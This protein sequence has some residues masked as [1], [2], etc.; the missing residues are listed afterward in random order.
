[1]ENIGMEGDESVESLYLV[2]VRDMCAPRSMER[3]L[4]STSPQHD[5]NLS[6]R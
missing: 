5:A 2:F 4:S 3:H 1:M 6:A